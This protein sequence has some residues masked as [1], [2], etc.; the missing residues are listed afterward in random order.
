[1]G[2]RACL[3]RYT[4]GWVG[5]RACLEGYGEDKMYLPN[6]SSNPGQSSP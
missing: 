4:G 5:S 2:S 3:E 1:V 6:R